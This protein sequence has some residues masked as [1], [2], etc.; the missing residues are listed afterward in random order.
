MRRLTVLFLALAACGGTIHVNGVMR[1]SSEMRPIANVP[2]DGYKDLR[3]FVHSGA[4]G[5][6]ASSG[7]PDCGVAMLE[8]TS[9]GDQKDNVACVPTE[10]LNT[11]V[12]LVRQRMRAYG[13]QVARDSSE[14]YDYD[15]TVR[16]KGMAPHRPDPMLAKAWATLTFSRNAKAPAQTLASSVDDKA[17]AA[18]FAGVA[19]DCALRDSS[20]DSFLAS[21][22]APMTPDFDVLAL[23]SDAVDNVLGCS[24]LARFFVDAR[25]KFPKAAAPAEKAADKPADK[26]SD[27]APDKASSDK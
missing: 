4:G 2:L 26:P 23:S 20:F 12:S 27:K 25:A 18:A 9:E 15:V 3:V 13:I 17:A 8:G 16:V 22:T 7:S 14:P 21:S 6:S 10:T 24:S 11:A 5:D 1:Q 19:K